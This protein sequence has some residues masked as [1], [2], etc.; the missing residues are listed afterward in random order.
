M[1]HYFINDERLPH[2]EFT[3]NYSLG[4]VNFSLVSDRGVFSKQRLDPGSEALL[5]VL[6]TRGLTGQILDLGAGIGV[7]GITLKTLRPSL[8]ITMLEINERAVNLA[9]RNWENSKLGE[10]NILV[11]DV[12]DALTNEQLFDAIVVNPPIRAGKKVVYAML[13]EGQKHLNNGGALYFVMRKS[14]GA[15]SA[16][17]YVESVYGNCHLLKR[18]AGYYIYQ[19]N[20]DR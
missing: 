11:S 6:L 19:A 8:H 9:K 3:I 12:Y 2:D 16:Q 15:K 18:D 7:M 1:S 17:A 20:V 14:H 5:K 4:G 13:G 10:S